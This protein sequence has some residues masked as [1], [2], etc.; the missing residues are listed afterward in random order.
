MSKPIVIKGLSA[1]YN[2][3]VAIENID[4][5]LREKDFLAVI[6]P[7]GGGKSTLLKAILGL[8]SPMSGSIEIFGEKPEKSINRI[9]YVP[10]KG[11]FDPSYPITVK[12]VVLMGLRS[13]KGLRPFY[14]QQ[15]R[16]MAEDAMR[17]TD[18]SELSGR[19]I[20]NL[21]G[22]QLQRAL[23]ARALAPKPDILLLDE[24]MASLDPGIRDCIYDTLRDINEDVAILIVTH[25]MGII[26]SE[27]KRVA[28]LN[29]SIIV[30]DEPQIT[31]EMMRLGFHCPMEL[32]AHGVPHRVLEVHDHD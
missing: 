24:P 10:Q 9:G 16:D 11:I 26:S 19:R 27:V 6:G 18:I 30:H 29:R 28:C 12:E 8:L 13:R 23:L 2:G 25:D 3:N 4:L 22:G 21:S 32:L 14:D 5:E 15:C 20:N 17:A 31:P 1:G 7:N